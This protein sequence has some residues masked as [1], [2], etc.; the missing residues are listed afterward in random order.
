VSDTNKLPPLDLEAARTHI[1]LINELAA[2]AISDGIAPAGIQ[3]VIC[4]YGQNTDKADPTKIQDKF[5][6]FCVGNFDE[7]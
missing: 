7:M 5:T 4:S 6:R 2:K 3:L 1:E